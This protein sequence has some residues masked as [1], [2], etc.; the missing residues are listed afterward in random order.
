LPETISHYLDVITVLAQKDF[1]IRYRN[2]VLG[3]LWSLLNPLAYMIILT[4]VFSL[5]LHVG[6]PNFPAWLVIGLLIWRFFSIGTSQGLVAIIANPSL[7]SKVYMPREVIVLSNSLANL[8]GAMLEFVALLPLLVL[9]GVSLTSY[10]LFL[11]LILISEFLLIFGLSLSLSALNVRYRD[12]YQL[13]EIAL[14]LG[15]FLSPIFYDVSLIPPRFRSLYSMN[16]VTSLIES[17]RS[18]FLLHQLPS[19]SDC[20]TIVVSVVVFVLIGF[21]VFRRLERRFAEEL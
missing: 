9:L 14:Q 11:P 7:V 19:L 21:I 8:L 2:S 4:V 6:I 18:I 15:F 5:L 13:W 16:P 17:T 20:V 3:F 10:V 1:K 12:F